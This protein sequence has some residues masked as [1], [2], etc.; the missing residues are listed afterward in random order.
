MNRGKQSNEPRGKRCLAEAM[1]IING[2]RQD[3]YGK[4]EDNF[5]TIAEFWTTY[6]RA[7][8]KRLPPDS[9]VLFHFRISPGDVAIM[10]T[11]LK[12]ARIA[13]GTQ[14]RDSFV[15]AAGYIGIAADMDKASEQSVE[16]GRSAETEDAGEKVNSP[17]MK[18]WGSAPIIDDEEAR[19][20]IAKIFATFVGRMQKGD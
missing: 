18:L 11:L 10:M 1:S 19:E 4:P 16:P 14:T 6:M 2:A 8:R 5:A 7:S 3:T 20:A 9:P 17:G 13:T 12:I 15:D